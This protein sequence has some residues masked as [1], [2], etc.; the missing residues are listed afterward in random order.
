MAPL[1]AGYASDM[2]DDELI[3]ESPAE[4]GVKAEEP[5]LTAI[6]GARL[7]A[8]EARP[9]LTALGFDDEQIRVWADTYIERVGAGTVEQFVDWIRSNENEQA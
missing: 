9:A 1:L 4:A 7:L 5:S 6:E 8:N 2:A 3:P